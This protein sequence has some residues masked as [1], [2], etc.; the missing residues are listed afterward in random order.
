ATHNRYLEFVDRLDS[1]V[2][3]IHA[4]LHENWGDADTHLPLFTGPAGRD[5]SGIR[6]LIERLRHRDFSGSIILEQWPDPPS[7]LNQAR[8]RLLALLIPKP[9]TETSPALEVPCKE[10][11]PF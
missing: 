7:L 11:P 10:Q 6:G 2:P 1:R 8:D 5:D 3:I 4:H 9:V